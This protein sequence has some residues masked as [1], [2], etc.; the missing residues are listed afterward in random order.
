MYDGRFPVA[1]KRMQDKLSMHLVSF[2]FLMDFFTSVAVASLKN[3]EPEPDSVQTC[4]GNLHAWPPLKLPQ[5]FLEMVL[6]VL[7]PSWSCTV[8]V[9]VVYHKFRF[10][11]KIPLCSHILYS[12]TGCPYSGHT[13]VILYCNL[14]I[15]H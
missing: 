15:N 2:S 7:R 3:Q 1:A 9:E 14:D 4:R 5:G 6:P 8:V 10:V 12:D 13:V 11:V